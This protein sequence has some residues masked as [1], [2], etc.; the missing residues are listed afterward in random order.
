VYLWYL[1]VIYA[2]LSLACSVMPDEGV[3]VLLCG[4]NLPF[5]LGFLA[6]FIYFCK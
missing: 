6:A 2:L 3:S 5:P 1:C 4:T